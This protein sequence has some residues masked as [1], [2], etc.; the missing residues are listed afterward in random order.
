MPDKPLGVYGIERSKD[1]IELIAEVSKGLNL[2]EGKSLENK[3]CG[4]L[5]DILEGHCCLIS[6]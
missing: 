6:D 1:I 3:V 2:A 4:V 5:K